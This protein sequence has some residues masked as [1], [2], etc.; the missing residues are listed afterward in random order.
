LLKLECHPVQPVGNLI[1][2]QGRKLLC[3]G[4]KGISMAATVEATIPDLLLAHLGALVL[5]PA[6]PIAWPNLSFTPPPGEYLEAT[7][8]PNTNVNLFVG[9]DA[10][11][12]HQG[13][14]QVTVVAK[15][16]LGIV[17]PNDIAGQ[18]VEH[19]AKG[20]RIDGQGFVLSIDEKPSVA[21]SIQEADR[22]RVP[23]TVRWYA[24]AK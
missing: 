24:F 16:G 2:V 17:G 1:V 3:H 22:I 18:I 7:F 11:T 20:T 21:P 13:L 4:R 23:V 6:L 8:M 19:F 10:T 12:Q 9:N 15:S 14:L 5:S